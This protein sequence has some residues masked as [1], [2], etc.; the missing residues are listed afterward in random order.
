[1]SFMAPRGKILKALFLICIPGY[2]VDF[3]NHMSSQFSASITKNW[4]VWLW[5][6][7]Y[8]LW[9]KNHISHTKKCQKIPSK[10]KKNI[11]NEMICWVL[12]GKLKDPPF[13]DM[14]SHFGK[15]ITKLSSCWGL[16]LSGER[17]ERGRVREKEK[18][19]EEKGR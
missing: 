2:H 12:W 1:M 13:W 17:R 8:I 7:N 10:K 19:I 18:G 9:L 14:R 5:K 11:E 6:K 3:S 16:K 4:V 15:C